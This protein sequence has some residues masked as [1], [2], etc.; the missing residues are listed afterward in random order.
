MSNGDEKDLN[1]WYN[2][3]AH[4]IQ[5]EVEEIAYD[6]EYYIMGERGLINLEKDIS[7]TSNE[8]I[9]ERMTEIERN[10][11]YLRNSINATLAILETRK[12]L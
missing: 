9:E 7:F 10:L 1:A 3:V 12:S 11:N 5:E 2:A 6:F 8:Y 4:S